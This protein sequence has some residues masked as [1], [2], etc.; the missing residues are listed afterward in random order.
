MITAYAH[1]NGKNQSI[2][3]TR[4]GKSIAWVSL[5]APTEE[6]IKSISEKFSIP[7]EHIHEAL[8][9]DLRSRVEF[10]GK[11]SAIYYKAPFKEEGDI[12][13]SGFGIF[14]IN[15]VVLTVCKQ[16]VAS[17]DRLGKRVEEVTMIC[18]LIDYINNEYHT[19]IENLEDNVDL[20]EE[21]KKLTKKS[22]AKSF[23]INR[24]LT[25]F[26]RAFIANLEVLRLLSRGY[27]PKHR[28]PEEIAQ[29]EDAYNEVY[30]L[31]E[32]ERIQREIVNNIFQLQTTAVS[33]EMNNVMKLFTVITV[34]MVVPTIITG[35]YGMNFQH[36][37]LSDN[38][39]GFLITN[40][41]LILIAVVMFYV[42]KKNDWV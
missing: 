19:Y 34:I 14:F 16:K 27:L 33:M 10:D 38:P 37:P 41:F 20:L 30:Q 31:L 24:T 15:N 36:I 7:L 35:S 12:I 4:I 11:V 6:E 1:I 22:I 28:K 25:Y 21:T 18:R 39:Y 13:T 40:A 2:P 9:E 3:L 42:F 26:H 23:D 29:F 32:M 17:I 5:I 8:D